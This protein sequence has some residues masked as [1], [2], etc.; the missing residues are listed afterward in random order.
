MHLDTRTE[1]AYLSRAHTHR[2]I[3]GRAES[4][5]PKSFGPTRFLRSFSPYDHF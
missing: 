5:G 4:F 3:F 2:P 1:Y